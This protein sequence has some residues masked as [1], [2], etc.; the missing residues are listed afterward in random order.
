MYNVGQFIFFYS[1]SKNQIFSARVIE[2][3]TVKKID[4]IESDYRVDIKNS[5]D[6]QFLLSDLVRV[7]KF[8]VFTEEAE[9]KSYMLTNAE[10]FIN[11]LIA[12]CN[13]KR[14]TYWGKTDNDILSEVADKNTE[15]IQSSNSMSVE[16]EN[17]VKA[18]IIDNTGVLQDSNV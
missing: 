12:N 18:N 2:E 16:L 8:K 7:K 4:S 6:S 9:L 15:V 5:E 17:G 1:S 3:I 13:E 11:K 14:M 10:N